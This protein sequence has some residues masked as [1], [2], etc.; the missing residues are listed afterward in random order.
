VFAK[1]A[2]VPIAKN[3]ITIKK[4]FII[5]FSFKISYKKG[6]VITPVPNLYF[7]NLRI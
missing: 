1:L 3:D 6:P 7:I 5:I 2:T 4:F